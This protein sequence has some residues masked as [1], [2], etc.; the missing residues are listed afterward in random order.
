MNGDSPTA[1]N[2]V[3][4]DILD[5]IE[6]LVLFRYQGYRRPDLTSRPF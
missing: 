5:T 3:I 1:A 6:N 4:A 2:R